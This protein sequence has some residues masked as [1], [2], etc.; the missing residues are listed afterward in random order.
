MSLS[1]ERTSTVRY[2]QVLN[3]MMNAT[4]TNGRKMTFREEAEARAAAMNNTTTNNN[5]GFSNYQHQQQQNYY[6]QN[7]PHGHSIHPPNHSSTPTSTISTYH[8]H[9]QS[10]YNN[11]MNHNNNN[12]NNFHHQHQNMTSYASTPQQPSPSYLNQQQQQRHQATI[13]DNNQLMVTQQPKSSR[14]MAKEARALWKN[15]GEGA[16][17]VLEERRKALFEASA[18]SDKS[19]CVQIVSAETRVDASN[20]EYTVYVMQ[21]ETQLAAPLTL[22]HRYSDFFRLHQL[23]SRNNISLKA[24]FPKKNFAGRLGNWTP[25]AHYAP[26]KHADL[27]H[28]RTLKLNVWLVDLCELLLQHQQQRHLPSSVEQSIIE[29]LQ[30]PHSAPCE[31]TNYISSINEKSFWKVSNP[32]SFTMGSSIRQ[33]TYSVQSMIMSTDPYNKIPIDFIQGAKGIIFLTVAKLGFIL[34]TRVGTGLMLVKR[35]YPTYSPP[36]NIEWSPPCAIGTI[37]MGGG[38]VVGGDITSYIILLNTTE[39]VESLTSGSTIQLGT[40]LDIAVGPILDTTSTTYSDASA[41]SYAIQSKGLFAG[42]S[43]EGSRIAIRP[44]V[45]SKF[46]GRGNI[47]PQ[48]L[49]YGSTIPPPRSAHC[50][51][52]ALQQATTSQSQQ[53]MIANNPYNGSATHHS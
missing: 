11:N 30:V 23:L 43:L 4:P 20:Q 49:F 50:L 38:L 6:N 13:N 21:V 48:E 44:D 2:Q 24:I 10:S 40:E 34:S 14:M 53:P 22:E 41:Y 29:F 36:F 16:S 3:K 25:A 19:F 12:N 45:N 33:A 47:S 52:E 39:A 46:Y 5:I 32:V 26:E 37:G 15:Q 8:T 28:R 9:H 7:P 51:Y 35:P 1:N 42:I 17:Q 18:V 27:I 31:K